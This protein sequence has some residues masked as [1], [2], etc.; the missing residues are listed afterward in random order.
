MGIDY[1]SKLIVGWSVDRKSVTKFLKQYN[2]G[3]CDEKQCFC[4]PKY[5]WKNRS[6]LPMQPELTFVV[7][8][9]YFDCPRFDQHC[10]L[11]LNVSATTKLDQFIGMV[12]QVDWD[13]AR[14]L[15]V[16]LGADDEPAGIWSVAHIW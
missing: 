1:D 4:G 13:A 6:A 10:Y 5:C 11:T 7:A 3:S 9:P 2:V 12:Q 14:K 15:A 8:S 16:Q